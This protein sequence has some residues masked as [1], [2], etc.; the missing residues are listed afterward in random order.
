M[1]L[2]WIFR[3][4]LM[5]YSKQYSLSTSSSRFCSNLVEITSIWCIQKPVKRSTMEYFAKIVNG[6]YDMK[7][8]LRCLTGF[9]IRLCMVTPTK[10]TSRTLHK[11]LVSVQFHIRVSE[12][13]QRI[14]HN[15][16]T[17]EFAWG[18]ELKSSPKNTALYNYKV[19]FTSNTLSTNPHNMVKHTWNTHTNKK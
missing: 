18:I 6:Y 12:E 2:W 1:I 9:W 5:K 17:G 11:R 15:V 10:L 13:L 14:N 19:S 7:L 8:Q 4:N 3:G 16:G